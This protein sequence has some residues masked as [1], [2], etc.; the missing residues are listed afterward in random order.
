M[1]ILAVKKTRLV[2]LKLYYILCFISVQLLHLDNRNKKC[3]L[4]QILFQIRFFPAWATKN[5]DLGGICQILLC[6]LQ[7]CKLEHLLFFPFFF[8]RNL[9]SNL[10][11]YKRAISGPAAPAVLTRLVRSVR[12]EDIHLFRNTTEMSSGSGCCLQSGAQEQTAF[13]KTRLSLKS[14]H[15]T[16]CNSRFPS[17]FQTYSFVKKHNSDVEIANSTRFIVMKS[18]FGSDCNEE[19]E[20]LEIFV[21]V[22]NIVFFF[23]QPPN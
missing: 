20:G 17:P 2:H 15:T 16:S 9:H 23:N 18:T 1:L 21:P 5:R 6:A 22:N 8:P 14:T 11:S 7:L 12:Q 13:I 4:I 10:T 3:Y 19:S